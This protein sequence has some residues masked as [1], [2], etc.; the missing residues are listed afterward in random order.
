M[1]Q[2]LNLSFSLWKRELIHSTAAAET[3]SQGTISSPS[4]HPEFQSL[5]LSPM[6]EYNSVISVHCN[7]HLQG[8]F[9]SPAS[10]SQSFTLV[11]QLECNGAILAQCNLHLPGDAGVRLDEEP[12]LE[13]SETT[14]LSRR[15]LMGKD[16]EVHELNNY[17]IKWAGRKLAT[18][19]S[20]VGQVSPS[21]HV[22]TMPHSF[23]ACPRWTIW[24][25]RCTSSS[26]LSTC[27]DEGC[28]PG[29]LCARPYA[30]WPADPTIS[31]LWARPSGGM[32]RNT[33][34]S[35]LPSRAISSPS[36]RGPHHV[37]S[38]ECS[39]VI[40][41]HCSLNFLGSSDPSASVSRVAGTTSTCHHTWLIF[42][43]LFKDRVG[44]PQWLTP[45]IPALWEAKAGGSPESETPSPKKEKK[46][47]FCYIVQAGLKLLA[48]SDSPAP[49]SQSAGIT[50]MSHHPQPV[51]MFKCSHITG[52]SEKGSGGPHYK[53]KLRFQV[54]SH[55]DKDN[56][57]RWPTGPSAS[58]SCDSVT[59]HLPESEGRNLREGSNCVFLVHHRTPYPR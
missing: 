39:G 12:A 9:G 38:L 22:S 56:K 4:P 33:R 23:S 36:E 7:L 46:M 1:S 3:D 31:S 44:Q 41:A 52:M 58:S 53:Q 8:S 16:P 29:G 15:V 35:W 51:S 13:I 54:Q 42:K 55:A 27:R 17:G 57:D 30:H 14:V 47:G 34:A 5:T 10:A 32:L 28:E 40:T 45:R 26:M 18:P 25:R 48:S 24:S 2:F 50:G 21:Y 49:A 6:L 59:V 37:T 20:G 19:V 11:A 43:L